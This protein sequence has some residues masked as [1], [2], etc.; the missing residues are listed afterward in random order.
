MSAAAAFRVDLA[1]ASLGYG[2]AL[3]PPASVCAVA[4][5]PRAVLAL[6]LPEVDSQ[7][8]RARMLQELAQRLTMPMCRRRRIGCRRTAPPRCRSARCRPWPG[9]SN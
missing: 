5:Q 1:D 9:C 7:S 2:H 3:L 4:W 8:T 6:Q